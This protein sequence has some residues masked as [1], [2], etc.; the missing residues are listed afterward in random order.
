MLLAHYFYPLHIELQKGTL[1]SILSCRGMELVAAST[2]GLQV[3]YAVCQ[4]QK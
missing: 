1:A 3:L 2:N 4:E